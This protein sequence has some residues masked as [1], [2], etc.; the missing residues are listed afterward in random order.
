MLRGLLI[1]IPGGCVKDHLEQQTV[2]SISLAQKPLWGYVVLWRETFSLRFNY[3]NFTPNSPIS[4]TE[5]NSDNISH[6]HPTCFPAAPEIPRGVRQRVH[7]HPKESA[8]TR[9]LLLKR[10]HFGLFGKPS[11]KEL[12]I[13][14]HQGGLMAF[15][16]VSDSLPLKYPCHRSSEPVRTGKSFQGHSVQLLHFINKI[17]S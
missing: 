8:Y 15:L 5:N 12:E 7:C 16:L 3:M 1:S 10:S 11:G 9:G 6:S 17:K 4:E 13:P 14:S 2:N